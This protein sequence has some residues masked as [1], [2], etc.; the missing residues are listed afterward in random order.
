METKDRL[1]KFSR[2]QNCENTGIDLLY[3]GKTLDDIDFIAT[4]DINY[5]NNKCSELE[6]IYNC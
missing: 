5:Y 4:D 2:S 1:D 3:K 6:P